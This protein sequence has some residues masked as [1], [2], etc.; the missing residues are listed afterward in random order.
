MNRS[1]RLMEVPDNDFGGA[2]AICFGIDPRQVIHMEEAS[3]VQNR[4][5]VIRAPRTLSKAAISGREYIVM[6]F[7]Q[8]ELL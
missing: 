6:R 5:A 8:P 4:L 7:A 1:S 3:K 2:A